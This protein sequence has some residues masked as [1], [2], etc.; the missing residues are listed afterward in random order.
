MATSGT[1]KSTPALGDVDNDGMLEIVVA[2]Y[3]TSN[4]D[5]LYCWDH[6]GNSEPGWPV[7][8]GYCR[9]SSPALGD[10]DNDG[11]LEIFIGGLMT[12]PYWMEILFG[13]DHEGQPL[14]NWPIELPHDGGMANINSS[15]TIAEIDNE[16]E[17]QEILVKTVDN[18]FALNTNGSLVEGYPYFLSDNS[19]SATHGPSQAIGD[20]D[21]DGDI[22]FVFV[23]ISGDVVYVDGSATNHPDYNDWPMYKHDSWGT[24]LYDFEIPTDIREVTQIPATFE[25]AQNY[26][27]PFNA[28]TSISFTVP[29]Q[30]RVSIIIYDLLGRKISTL[31]DEEKPPGTYSINYDASSLSSGIYFYRVQAEDYSESK[32][33]ILVK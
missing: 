16:T 17:T 26:P 27:N 19:N 10:I 28:K 18:I 25:L 7:R 33:M 9:L 30:Q 24:G 20:L 23:S 15:P 6:E 5:Y 8:A 12:S 22:D 31:L 1:V 21:N 2:A 4:Q 14:I 11:D 32:R 3:D 29:D 13:F